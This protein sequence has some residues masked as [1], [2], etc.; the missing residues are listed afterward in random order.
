MFH[1][2]GKIT[3]RILSGAIPAD[4]LN[5]PRTQPVPSP[6]A[7]KGGSGRALGKGAKRDGTN[8]K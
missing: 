2:L 6:K 1:V 4:S 7:V 8:R 5:P 3:K